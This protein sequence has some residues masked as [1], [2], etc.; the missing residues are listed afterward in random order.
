MKKLL[1]LG[2]L[3][4]VAL[5]AVGKTTSAWSYLST[6]VCQVGAEAKNQVPTKFELE[7]IRNEI[8]GLD[9]DITQMVRPIAEYKSVIEKMRKDIARSQ[10]NIDKQ[11]KTLLEVVTELQENPKQIT[12][13]DK[14]YTPEQIRRQV[15]RDT[16]SLKQL[17]KHVKVQQQVLEAK[18]LSL[19]ATQEQLAKVISKKREYEVRLA[20]LEAEEETLQIARIGSDI[21]IDSGRATLIEDAL[22]A[23]EQR[24][25]VER[26]VAVLKTGDL[27][28]I[29]LHDRRTTP[30]DLSTI[31]SYL[32]GHEAAEKTANNK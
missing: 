10:T 21:K 7:R 27:A 26:Q 31:R 5:V 24:Q 15:T 13:N 12:I 17:E 30:A 19:K 18:E 29:P 16:E 23:V 32:E 9:G 3:G 25:D 8:A 4:A 1:I 14:T 6:A 22:N 20:Q 28:N 11:K 2:L